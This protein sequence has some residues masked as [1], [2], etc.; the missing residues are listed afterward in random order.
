MIVTGLSGAGKASIL[1]T[2][3]DL[4]YEAVDNPPLPLLA[5]LV[6]RGEGRLAVV[7]DARTRGFDAG[8]VLDLL[9]RVRSAGGTRPEL[10]FAWADETVL[11]RRY[12]ETRRRHPLAPLGRVTDGIREEEQL[13]AQL[14]EAADLLVDT[15]ELAPVRLRQLIEAHFGAESP[16]GSTAGLSVALISFAFSSGLP[17]EADL[18]FDARFLRNPHYDPILRHRTGLDAEVGAYVEADPDFAAFFGMIRSMLALLLPRFVQEGK[19]YTTIAIGCTG[20][21]HRSVH[22]V[23]LVSTHL[24]E[25]GWRPSV[26]HRELARETASHDA[27]LGARRGEVS[28]GEPRG[29]S[30]APGFQAQEA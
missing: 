9:H 28:V 15:T 4:G 18:V 27:N 17:R 29:A 12:T 25:A 26:V 11:L 22:L 23:E 2:L 8:A 6:G 5:D 19:K 14:R 30:A 20:G 13:T 7:V 3:E 1:R 16:A 24:A 10:V 21:R